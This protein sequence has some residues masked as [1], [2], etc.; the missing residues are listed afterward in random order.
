M[1]FS[2]DQIR[3]FIK[4]AVRFRKLQ[5]MSPIVAQQFFWNFSSRRERAK[6]I[7]AFVLPNPDTPATRPDSAEPR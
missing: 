6:A 7:D 5:E 3:A 4:D 2:D 1:T